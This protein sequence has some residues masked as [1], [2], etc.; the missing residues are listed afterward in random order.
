MNSRP[1]CSSSGAASGGCTAAGSGTSVPADL[2][3]AMRLVEYLEDIARGSDRHGE[4]ARP[5]SFPAGCL[6]RSSAGAC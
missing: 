1:P 2:K 3:L 6:G 5:R 4:L